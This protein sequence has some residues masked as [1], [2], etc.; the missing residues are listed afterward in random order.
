MKDYRTTSFWLETCGDDL[1]PRPPLDG[2]E[3]VDVAILGAG[4]SG[5]WTAYYLQE[6]DPSLK[7][8]L[9]EKEIA[10]YGASGR[11]GGW[12][13]PGFPLSGGVLAERFGHDKARRLEE[14]M[15]AAVDEV[16]R[17]VDKEGIDAQF[18]KSGSLRLARGR[19]QLPS[20]TGYKTMMDGLGLGRYF[21]VLDAAETAKRVHVTDV[22]ASLFTPQCAVIQPAKLVRGLAR[23]V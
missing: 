15:F 3:D 14:G 6:R 23:A 2:S 20:V 7:I 11:N 4:F 21:E 1:T 18:L 9:V 10:G 8:A 5:L 16:G 17:V 19:H 13:T 12:C 22:V